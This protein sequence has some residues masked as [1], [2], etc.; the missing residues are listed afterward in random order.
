MLTYFTLEEKIAPA[1]GEMR[2]ERKYYEL[3]PETETAETAGVGGRPQ[4]LTHEKVKRIERKDLSKIRPGTIVEVELIADTKNDYDYVEFT[5]RL[6]AGFEYVKPGS[7]YLSWYLAIY[8]EFRELGRGKNSIRYRIRAQLDGIY[9]ALPASGRGVYAP[10][11][12]CNTGNAVWKIG[13]EQ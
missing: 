7:G 9:Q 5:D 11:L 3:V 2:L 8:A 6:P 1:G 4:T 12:K 13:T 10:E